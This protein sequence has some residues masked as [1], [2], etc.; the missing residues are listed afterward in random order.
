M[1]R[2]TLFLLML[3]CLLR[4]SA[5]KRQSIDILVSNQSRNMIVFTPNTV[6]DNMPLMIV[7]HGMNQNPEYQFDGDKLYEM[8]D[9]AKFIVAYLRSDGNT[10]DINGD[11]DMNFVLN[12]ID[13]MYT[14]Y[15][16]NKNRVYWSG[17]SMGSMLIYHCMPKVADKFAAFAPTSGVQFSEQ[18]WNNLKTKVNLIHCHS[19][20]D[21]VFDYNQYGIH[22]YVQNIAV[23]NEFNTYIKL[24]NY[25]SGGYSGDKE[26][27]TNTSTGNI[28]ELYSY[29]SGG[30][31][32]S[33][34]NREEI[35]NFCKRFSLQTI[36]EEYDAIYKKAQELISEWKDTPEMTQKSV[37]TAL[38]K[39]LATY[40]PDEM[41]TDEKKSVAPFLRRRV[42]D[43]L[44]SF[45]AVR[46][47]NRLSSTLTSI[48]IYV[49]DSL[50]WRAMLPLKHK[51]V[52]MLTRD[53]G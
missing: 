26:V 43:S 34:Y 21:N 38:K 7:T 46:W 45:T 50:T 36:A 53:S 15:K 3:G 48:F 40:S 11:K 12:S 24:E 18:P 1:K 9:T 2:T 23:A 51:T 5:Y 17:F 39:A 27:W 35:W 33:Y 31:W 30:H 44:N 16:I 32:P 13:E 41:D 47:S 25:R 6:N 28:V 49:S 29:N 19:Y 4:L 37:Y 8:V 10:W 14:R 20:E 22:D 52:T 42:P